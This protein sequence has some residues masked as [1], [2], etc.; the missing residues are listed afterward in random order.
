MTNYI[1]IEEFV[2]QGYLQELNRRFLH[3]LGLAL[4]VAIDDDGFHEITGI[5]DHR[6]DPE[7]IYFETVNQEKA[8][9]I[10]SRVEERKVPRIEALGYWLQPVDPEARKRQHQMSCDY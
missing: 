5:R 7:G 8:G 4:E 6:D 9:N 2:K 3:P 1:G 10:D